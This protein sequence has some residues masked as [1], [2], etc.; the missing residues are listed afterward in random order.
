MTH[1]TIDKDPVSIEIRSNEVQE[2]LGQIPRWIIRWGTT[3]IALTIIILIAGSALFRYPDIL[4]ST[5]ILTTQNPPVNL[6]AKV[7]GKIDKLFVKDNQPVKKGDLIALLETAANYKHVLEAQAISKNMMDDLETGNISAS[8]SILELGEMQSYFAG[9]L[10][11][12]RDYSSFLSL[13][14]FR[15]KTEA[16]KQE[17][18]KYDTYY[19]RLEEQ[20]KVQERDYELASRQ[21]KRDSLLFVQDVIS[22]SDFE[23]SESGMLQ[24]AFSLKETQTSLASAKIQVSKLSQQILDLELEYNKEK[25]QKLSQLNETYDRLKAETEIWKQKYLLISPV[26]G[27]I[28]FTKFWNENQQVTEGENVFTIIPE[29]PG[30][31]LGKI[32]LP[33]EGAGKVK[34][35]QKVNIKFANYP[36]MEYGMVRGEIS[37]ISQVSNMNFYTVEVVL[38]KGLVTNYGTKIEFRQEM[39]GMAEIITD[40]KSLLRRII[41]PVKSVIKKQRMK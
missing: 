35:G 8:D 16:V 31:I 21:F 30:E 33:V 18:K 25:E 26:D 27:T 38:N 34:K 5:I 22:R 2:L 39:P 19:L 28:S 1:D 24:K 10:K 36:F 32:N 7:S 37:S 11:E 3:V 41:N 9:F 20:S 15:K 13:D 23:K 40:D 14:Y 6:V 4:Y 17:L 12:Y 29:R